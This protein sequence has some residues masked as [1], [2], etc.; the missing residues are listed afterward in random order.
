ML[1]LPE[2]L[3]CSYRPPLGPRVDLQDTSISRR[4]LYTHMRVI[5]LH[6]ADVRC[7]T[8]HVDTRTIRFL[9][10]FYLP[11]IYFSGAIR[12]NSDNLR[13]YRDSFGKCQ[14]PTVGQIW[15]P[16]RF[17]RYPHAIC[18]FQ[19]PDNAWPQEMTHVLQQST[20]AMVDASMPTELC[21]FFDESRGAE[22]PV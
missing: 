12:T 15:F 2:H 19:S 5:L 4:S 22:Y 16:P 11:S 14:L 13:C 6:V 1:M 20:S 10:L 7:P 18:Q 3:L 9:F 8:R 21:A 17:A